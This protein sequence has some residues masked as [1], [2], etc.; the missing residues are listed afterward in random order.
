[1][2]DAKQVVNSIVLPCGSGH[3]VGMRTLRVVFVAL[4][5]L[6]ACAPAA[7]YY[8]EGVSMTK[9]EDDLV[10]CKVAAVKDAPV[11]TQIRRGA[12][13]YYPGYLRCNNSGQCYHT[14]GYFYPGE[15]YSVDV[16]AGLRRDLENR[17]MAR[18]G[19]APIELPRCR[20]GVTVAGTTDRTTRTDIMPPLSQN[21]CI[22][23]GDGG[24]VRIIDPAS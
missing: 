6:S 8:R 24:R 7:V 23:E 16:N 10:N 19:Y 4:L 22:I 21:S 11:A 13:R 5:T 17:C 3:P 12:P 1:M 9:M 18:K 2:A 20:A 15:V 14:G